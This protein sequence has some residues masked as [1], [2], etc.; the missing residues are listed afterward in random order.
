M[1]KLRALPAPCKSCPYRKDVPSGVWHEDEYKRLPRY[2]GEII[3]QA[4]NGAVGLFMCHQKNGC[5]CSGWLACHGPDKLLATRL[6]AGSLDPEVFSYET[7]VPVFSSG[8]EAAEHG[9]RDINKPG[10]KAQQV[11][12]RLIKKLG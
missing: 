12:D 10:A 6:N 8:G 9:M 1:S 2:D 11:M 3:D 5:L 7:K 4:I